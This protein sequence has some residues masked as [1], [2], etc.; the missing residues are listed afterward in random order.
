MGGARRSCAFACLRALTAVERAVVEQQHAGFRTALPAL[1][2][3]LLPVRAACGIVRAVVRARP[4]TAS[5]TLTSVTPRR[6]NDAS[7]VEPAC[8][9]APSRLAQTNV[10]V[11]MNS[12][13]AA[14]EP[15]SLT[16]AGRSLALTSNTVADFS[17]LSP[18]ASGVDQSPSRHPPRVNARWLWV[19]PS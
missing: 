16:P 14:Q 15:E 13:L 5:V 8:S 12:R 10:N 17:P 2:G 7:A 9:P 4:G 19:R 3:A 1:F 18:S 6:C 11:A